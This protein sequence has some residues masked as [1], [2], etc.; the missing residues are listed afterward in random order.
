MADCGPEC[1]ETLREIQHYLDHEVDD[2]IRV[3]VEVHLSGCDP[4]TDRAEFHKHLKALL[5]T[6]CAQNDIP[7]GLHDRIR[8]VISTLDTSTD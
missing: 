2:V 3:R 8:Q 7:D 1:E 4:C 6:K 5:Q